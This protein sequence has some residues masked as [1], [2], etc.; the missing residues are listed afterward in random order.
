MP[1]VVD[2]LAYTATQAARIAW[3]AGHYVAA[4]QIGKSFSRETRKFEPEANWP[5]SDDIRQSMYELFEIDWRDIA[6]GIYRSPR[7][8][9]LAKWL[10]LSPKFLRDLAD[11]DRRRAEGGH[12]EVLTEER[13][14]RYPRYYLQN[15]HFQ[16]DG[17]LSRDSARLYDFQVETLF[18]GTADAMRRRAL[19]AIAGAIAHRDQ[20]KLKFLDIAA[21]TGR[22]LAE[23]KHNWPRLPVVALDLSADYLAETRKTLREWSSVETIEAN[24]ED[25]P[26]SSES[27][28]IASCI[29]L[30]HELPPKI[31][32]R[33]AAEIAR[34]LKPGGTFV[35]IDSIQQ[36]DNVKF[37]ALT[38]MFPTVFHEPYYASY[39]R[40]DVRALFT[41]VGLDLV[42][43]ELAFLS[44]VMAFKRR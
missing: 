3:F 18:S 34:V 24:A 11:V 9:H 29:F 12:S 44:K 32:P 23:V 19:P 31:R 5:T 33:V 1:S 17:W 13:K 10:T 41:G 26:L 39:A 8:R 28:D 20:R 38:E 21:G 7:E 30:F 35:F 37:D 4:R 15:F 40:E 36:T 42:S 43:S 6:A 16:T 2:R 25:M 27:M 22:F 14:G